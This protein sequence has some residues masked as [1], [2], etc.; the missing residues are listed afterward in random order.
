MPRPTD[1]IHGVRMSPTLLLER[2]SRVSNPIE[3][4]VGDITYLSVSS[5]GGVYL[6]TWEDH[7]SRLV[8]GWQIEETLADKMVIRAMRKAI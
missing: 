4:Q 2:E 3:V 6:V 8:A 5:G 7:G 1:S